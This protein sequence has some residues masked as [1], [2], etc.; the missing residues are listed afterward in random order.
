MAIA[1][2]KR[3]RQVFASNYS[4]RIPFSDALPENCT[5][6]PVLVKPVLIGGEYFPGPAVQT[7]AQILATIQKTVH[8]VWHASYTNKIGLSTD[9]M[10]VVD[11]NTRVFGVNN[12]RVMDSNSFP[13]LP[14]G[15]PRS[16]VYALAEKI[17]AQILAGNWEP[18]E[19]V[20]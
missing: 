20:L 1:A 7:D 4:R 5:G 16:T 17:A 15:H 13:I 18:R 11:L 6:S 14:P 19:R 12:L 2:Y 3:V 9:P 10:A 8:I